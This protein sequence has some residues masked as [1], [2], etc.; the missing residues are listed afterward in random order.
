MEKEITKYIYFSFEKTPIEL[1]NTRSFEF[2]NHKII[3]YLNYVFVQPLEHTSNH[4]NPNNFE[5]IREKYNIKNLVL[6]DY[7]KSK[8]KIM[9]QTVVAQD[10][11]ESGNFISD[12]QIDP[13]IKNM[14]EDEIE[15]IISKN[16]KEMRKAAEKL[17]FY[18]AAKLRDENIELK[19]IL[20]SKLDRR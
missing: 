2:S 11:I 12:L 15:K 10:K 3:E 14:N 4:I 1:A 19:K 9:E 5:K 18:Q 8:K 7:L 17:D 20:K 13:V 6:I 16:E